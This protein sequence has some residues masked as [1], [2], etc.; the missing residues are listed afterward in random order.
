MSL[1]DLVIRNARVFDGTGAPA[2]VLDVAVSGDRITKV[3]PIIDS[4][5]RQ[6]V[7]A[8]GLALSPGFI[9]AHTHDDR[10]VLLDPFH[11]CKLSQGV[12]TVV[13]GNCGISLAPMVLDIRPPAPLD[14]IAPTPQDLFASF[15]DYFAA[16]EAS[17]CAVNIVAQCGHSSLR[18]MAM[19][20]W[21]QPA[22]RNE[23][24]TMRAMLRKALDDGAAGFSTGLE[25]PLSRASTTSE[26]EE[27]AQAG[28]DYATFHTTHM[29]N[30]G[31]GVMDSL[32]ESFRIGREARLPVIISHHKC[33]GTC[34]AGRSVETLQAISVARESQNIGLDAYPYVASSTMLDIVRINRARQTLIAWSV[35]YPQHQGR[36]FKDVVAE[37][38]LTPEDAVKALSPAGGIYFQ[39]DEQDVKRILSYDG[40][41]IGSDGLPHD[42]HPHPR[43]WGTFPRVLGHYARDEKLFSVEEAVRKMTHLT[44]QTFGLTD[45]GLVAEGAFADLVLF[46]P[47]TIIDTAT[48]AEPKQTAAG[49]IGVWVNGQHSWDGKAATGARPGRALRRQGLQ[50]LN[51]A[52]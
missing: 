11:T 26:V 17:P 5:G 50:R 40:T 30:E 42:T 47:Q 2:R 21:T 32:A 16:F 44:A 46:D 41:M 18:V 24:D 8:N 15:A 23:I 6:E 10:A 33:V 35:P 28:E 3:A 49:I 52:A 25:Y 29:R 22:T 1:H 39:M 48:F 45:R 13:V 51:W 14:L 20:D 37:M 19:K 38:G 43:L 34:N 31:D 7:D 4:K 27:I 12:T 36:D 9:D